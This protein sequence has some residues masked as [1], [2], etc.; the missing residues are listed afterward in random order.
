MSSVL[1]Q[2]ARI[3]GTV[4]C[5]ADRALPLPERLMAEFEIPPHPIMAAET[6]L[7]AF[8]RQQRWVG[9]GVRIMALA[10]AP[11]PYGRMQ[12]GVFSHLLLLI[13]V[14]LLAKLRFG[15]V[16][17]A[18]VACDMGVV[19]QAALPLAYR[20]V[21]EFVCEIVSVVTVKTVLRCGWNGSN[22]Q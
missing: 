16:Q 17:K 1:F 13:L 19:A 15:L 2:Q 9:G 20:G 8:L 4:G 22:Q 14:A 11:F 3:L 5:M 7:A 10:A 6:Q 21:D 12:I 18:R